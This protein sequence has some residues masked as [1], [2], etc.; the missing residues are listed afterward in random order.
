MGNFFPGSLGPRDHLEPKISLL[1]KISRLMVIFTGLKYDICDLFAIFG[2]RFTAYSYKTNH[3]AFYT[4]LKLV[5]LI[6]QF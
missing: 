1:F 6:P 3:V 4:S 5:F 2:V